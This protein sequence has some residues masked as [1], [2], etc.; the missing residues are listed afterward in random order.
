M[1]KFTN[2]NQIKEEYFP[3]RTAKEQEEEFMK[4]AT[5]SEIGKYWAE[6]TIKKIK[7]NL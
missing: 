6:Q 3:L 1:K 2:I 7:G 5:P 4:T